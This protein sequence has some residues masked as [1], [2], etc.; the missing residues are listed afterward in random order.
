M[1][2][3]S[4]S[5]IRFTNTPQEKSVIFLPFFR[6][7]V[8][9]LS[10][11]VIFEG[12]SP[13]QKRSVKKVLSD[14]CLPQSGVL[15]VYTA[16]GLVILV[17]LDESSDFYDLQQAGLTLFSV[18]KQ[19]SVSEASLLPGSLKK[20]SK[21]WESFLD[22]VFL[23]EYQF[24]SYRG[25]IHSSEQEKKNHVSCAEFTIV[26]VENKERPAWVQ[27]VSLTKNII[28]TPPSVATPS[29]VEKQVR[30]YLQGKKNVS[31]T[32]L[33][34]KEL[35]KHG[36]NGILSVGQA[37]D[38]ESRLLIIEYN[39]GKKGDKPLVLVGKGVTYD[40]GG[41]S[42]K[43]SVAMKGM[44]KDLGGASTVIGA[45]Y[46]IASAELSQNVV[47]VIPLAENLIGKDAYKPDDIICMANGVTVEIT[48]T[49]AEGR[50]LLGDALWY[51]ENF[52]SPK[53]ILDIATLTGACVYAVGEDIT[54]VFSTTDELMNRIET[55]SHISHEP[56]WRLPLYSRYKK[57]IRSKVA[58][59]MNA[60]YGFK[61]G[62]IQAA[63]FLQHFVDKKTPWAHF[64]IAFSSYNDDAN[65]ATGQQVR[66]FFEIAKNNTV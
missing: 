9:R 56:V 15:P 48:N 55:A 60:A 18:A 41:L 28:N 50:L 43:P 11:R 47:A 14:A 6:T 57:K 44:K 24:E 49:D 66:T 62:T 64:D 3:I 42:L 45:L 27:G 26:G 54:A 7:D 35:Q 40:T 10:S 12:L 2:H 39:G 20:F 1:T 37:S 16:D 63:L 5:V 46:A 53:Y 59:I 21:K 65:R 8:A 13:L 31:I 36:M 30:T 22:G 34:E 38:E 19:Y 17:L 61:A 23:G 25:V 32:A 51:A 29:F 58:D 33:H 4:D 52:Y